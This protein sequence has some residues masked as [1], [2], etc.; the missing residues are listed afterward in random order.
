MNKQSCRV[1]VWVVWLTAAVAISQTKAQ[2]IYL[3]PNVEYVTTG[4][5]SEFVLELKV[6]AAVSSLKSF[7]FYVSFDDTKLDTVEVLE[8]TLLPSS[9]AI[10]YFYAF[11]VN[12][13]QLQLEGLI[14]GAGVDVAGPGTLA[15]IRL[16]TLDTG[17]VDFNVLEHRMRDVN[18]DVI[19]S[20]ASGGSVYINVPPDPFDLISPVGGQSVSGPPGGNFNLW[21]LASQSVY[22]G[23]SVEYTVEYGTSLTFDPSQTT[24]VTALTDPWHTIQVD[25]LTARHGGE[26]TYYWR[27]TAAGDLYGWETTSTPEVESFQFQY[28]P[29]APDPFD[30]VSPVQGQLIEG[31]PGSSFEL[32]WTASQSQ[33]P[34]ESV[35]YTVEYG[36]SPAFDPPQTTTITDAWYPWQTIQIDDFTALY[37]Y[38]GVYY[39]RVTAIGNMNGLETPSAPESESFQFQGLRLPE[40]F[41]LLSPVHEAVISDVTEV[42]FDWQ[43]ATTANPGDEIT[44]YALY[45]GPDPLVP[46]GALVTA[47]LTASDAL[48][49]VDAFPPNQPLYWIVSAENTYDLVRWSTSTF[50]FTFLAG[51]CVGRI[52]DANNNGAEEPTIGDITTMID[53][54]FITG[55]CDDVIECIAE[56]DANQSGGVDP[57]C[58]DITIGDITKLIDY[59]F[60]SGKD[61]WD[62][63]YGLGNLPPCL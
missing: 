7:T 59:L 51:C 10:T 16:R 15:T 26:G 20:T 34:G 55:T 1:M 4:V 46:T 13:N 19:A 41:D 14:M 28:E 5:G 32:T 33:Y 37:G 52:G 12:G 8:G 53:A 27:V 63:G 57:D 54:K 44:G 43:D 38:E 3:D 35:K 24:T 49:S 42:P 36:P 60:I 40:P 21:W 58:G 29:V 22:P 2:S 47:A 25:D 48:V 61:T 50:T 45:I 56:A 31:L 18:V 39:W 30:L 17:A 11:I 9:G 62:E 23:E 6:D